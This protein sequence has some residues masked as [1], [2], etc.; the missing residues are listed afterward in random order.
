MEVLA[1]SAAAN[2]VLIASASLC[3]PY[4]LLHLSNGTSVLLC[5]NP[6]TGGGLA[7]TPGACCCTCLP[8]CSLT[9]KVSWHAV[10][11]VLS[12]TLNSERLSL[13]LC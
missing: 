7:R 8:V 5:A 11:Y 2:G 10:G 1:P 6:D 9:T 4:L 3:D 12:M 13:S